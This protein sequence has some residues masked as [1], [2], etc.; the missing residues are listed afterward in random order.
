[1]VLVLGKLSS[2][3]TT[4]RFGKRNHLRSPISQAVAMMTISML[5]MMM[6]IKIQVKKFSLC[7]DLITQKLPPSK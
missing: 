6:K 2:P 5:S 1:M 4:I 7:G 3:T